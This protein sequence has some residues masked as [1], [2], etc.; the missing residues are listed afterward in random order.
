M[1][2][3]ESVNY[4]RLHT[5]FL[6]Q[7]RALHLYLTARPQ[8]LMTLLQVS[9]ILWSMYY[10]NYIYAE[11]PV[12]P[13]PIKVNK[14]RSVSAETSAREKTAEDEIKKLKAELAREKRK[15]P[16]ETTRQENPLLQSKASKYDEQRSG[17]SLI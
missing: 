4:I 3:N 15:A 6:D 13:Q 8:K 2:K 1:R 11:K 16:E 5:K 10:I 12:T 9:M 14:P 17:R 7:A